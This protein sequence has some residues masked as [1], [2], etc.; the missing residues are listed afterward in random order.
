MNW[1]HLQF[2]D[3]KT[4]EYMKIYSAF[5]C[6]VW[7]SRVTFILL[8]S[9]TLYQERDL[10]RQ[11]K[12]HPLTSCGLNQWR[13][14]ADQRD[15]KGETGCLICVIDPLI[16]DHIFLKNDLYLCGHMALLLASGFCTSLCESIL[17]PL[18]WV[19]IKTLFTSLQIAK[20][21]MFSVLYQ[22]SHW[23]IETL[24]G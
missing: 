14:L 8:L 17:C 10:D 6:V 20:F 24:K 7:F 9:N 15:V 1:V 12:S 22:F 23:Y 18:L 4:W 16:K 5:L 3:L 21:E 11:A 19:F 13:T 2:R